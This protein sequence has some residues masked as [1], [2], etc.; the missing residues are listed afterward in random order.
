MNPTNDIHDIKGMV[1]V[2]HSWWWLLIP[3]ALILIGV[4]IW[5]WRRRQKPVLAPPIIPVLTPQETALAALQQLRQDSPPV[6]EFYTRLADI[7]RQYIEAQFSLH[8]PERTTEEFLAEAKLPAQ[9]M[10]LL[11]EF[12]QEADLVK[13]ARHRPGNEDMERTAAAGEKFIRESA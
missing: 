10:A 8:A 3:L 11:G 12:L 4:A 6:E 9:Q 7:V 1:P 2:P 5:L 13:F